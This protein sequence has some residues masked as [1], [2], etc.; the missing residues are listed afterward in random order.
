MSARLRRGLLLGLFA[1]A[2]V[3]MAY[4]AIMSVNSLVTVL[5]FMRMLEVFDPKVAALCAAHL[6]ATVLAM[7]SAFLGWK[8]LETDQTRPI[9]V[10]ALVGGVG[11]PLIMHGGYLLLSYW[12]AA[13]G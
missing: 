1:V 13:W 8:A 10:W 12:P 2:L 4:V 3:S 5:G 11:S 9:V 6:A 7:T